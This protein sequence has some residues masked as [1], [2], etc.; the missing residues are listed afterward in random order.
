MPKGRIR[1]RSSKNIPPRKAHAFFRRAGWWDWYTLAEVRWR[2]ARALYV[3]SAW[4]GEKM[5]GLVLLTGDGRLD[6]ELRALVVEEAYRNRGIGSTLMK[7]AGAKVQKLRPCAFN[8]SV[9]ERRTARFYRRF[10]FRQKRG[11]W[12]MEHGP[13]ARRLQARVARYHGED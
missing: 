8:L 3:A 9:I 1:Y 11:T 7:M 13:T 5:V 6:V 2:L 12:L 10:G 4:D